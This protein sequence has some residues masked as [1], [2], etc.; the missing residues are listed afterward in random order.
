MHDDVDSVQL[1]AVQQMRLEKLH[2]LVHQRGGVR[3]DHSAHVPGRVRQSL[4]RS[5]LDHLLPSH[6]T[7][8]STA[9]R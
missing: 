8:R 5:D 4:I 1:D 2:A 6:A 3:R 7:E 9:R